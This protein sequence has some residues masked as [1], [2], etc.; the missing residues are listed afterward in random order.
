[1]NNPT[2]VYFFIILVTNKYVCHRQ[3]IY[4]ENEISSVVIKTLSI[5]L[6]LLLL[7]NHKLYFDSKTFYGIETL[8]TLYSLALGHFQLIIWKWYLINLSQYM[9]SYIIRKQFELLAVT[10]QLSIQYMNRTQ[11]YFYE[12]F[13]FSLWKTLRS[14]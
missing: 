5:S 11:E 4:K 13:Y 10:L 7:Q 8:P 3:L 14:K 12:I 6:C 1:M 2:N 9:I